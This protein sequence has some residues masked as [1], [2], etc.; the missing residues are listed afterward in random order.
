MYCTVFCFLLSFILSLFSSSLSPPAS[1]SLLFSLEVV[2]LITAIVVFCKMQCFHPFPPSKGSGW[3]SG[4][5][6]AQGAN[7][8]ILAMLFTLP[9]PQFPHMK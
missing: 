8:V 5:E 2:L 3:V 9:T 7:S 6:L 4:R 1:F